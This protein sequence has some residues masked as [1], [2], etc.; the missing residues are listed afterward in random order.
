MWRAVPRGFVCNSV[1]KL[2]LPAMSTFKS[3]ANIPELLADVR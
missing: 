2:S 1:C 3:K